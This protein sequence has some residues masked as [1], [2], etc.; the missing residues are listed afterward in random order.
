MVNF[1]IK[2]KNREREEYKI[3]NKKFETFPEAV[4][5]AYLQRAKLGSQWMI[6]SVAR[7]HDVN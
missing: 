7:L 1:I 2:M 5:H 4:S 6:I 3:H